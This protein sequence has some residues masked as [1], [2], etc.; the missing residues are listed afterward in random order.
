[1]CLLILLL[2]CISHITISVEITRVIAFNNSI[3]QRDAICGETVKNR[4]W[5][6][7]NAEPGTERTIALQFEANE[8]W[9]QIK[10]PTAEFVNEIVWT[11]YV[12]RSQLSVLLDLYLKVPGCEPSTNIAITVTGTYQGGICDEE[13]TDCMLRLPDSAISITTE[14][15][16]MGTLIIPPFNVI[17]GKWT[18]P[19]KLMIPHR[20]LPPETLN[21]IPKSLLLDAL[22]FASSPIQS[23]SDINPIQFSYSHPYFP[24]RTYVYIK[25][26][27]DLAL[28]QK[29]E[30]EYEMKCSECKF[31]QF[32]QIMDQPHPAIVAESSKQSF[33]PLYIPSMNIWNKYCFVLSLNRIPVTPISV[34]FELCQEM[35]IEPREVTFT[36][37]K[38]VNDSMHQSFCITPIQEVQCQLRFYLSGPS[39]HEYI[40]PDP[41]HVYSKSSA[42]LYIT[43]P[44]IIEVTNRVISTPQILKFQRG[45][46]LDVVLSPIAAENGFFTFAPESFKINSEVMQS[47]EI[48]FYVTANVDCPMK[49]EDS[50]TSLYYVI[51]W[52]INGSLGNY[53]KP[54]P[55]YMKVVANMEELSPLETWCSEDIDCADPSV[56]QTCVVDE[57]VLNSSREHCKP[58]FV[59]K[60]RQES[61]WTVYQ[62]LMI[63]VVSLVLIVMILRFCGCFERKKEEEEVDSEDETEERK[64]FNT[65]ANFEE[66]Q[67]AI[68]NLLWQIYE[69]EQNLD[70]NKKYQKDIH[71]KNYYDD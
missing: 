67:V 47:N 9:A 45:E 56:G 60:R 54:T 41:I 21:I 44:S 36:K 5:I 16:R 62:Y 13:S 22:Q 3:T 8:I 40:K 63:A 12:K 35:I 37:E 7:L 6:S 50:N 64:I 26:R 43:F 58:L 28:S 19:I 61:G 30:I 17:R 57:C 32:A 46:Y 53:M 65:A 4:L 11:E 18:K 69:H 23:I 15:P 34:S 20:L 55:L 42:L 38:D 66:A 52:N 48:E 39:V 29:L 24:T 59:Q 33:I 27:E 49:N 31:N 71:R 25:A 10:A 2:I 1:M 70:I 51:H 14:K 68:E